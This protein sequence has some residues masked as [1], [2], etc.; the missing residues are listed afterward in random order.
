MNTEEN[1]DLGTESNNPS[2]DNSTT[3]AMTEKSLADIISKKLLGGEEQAETDATNTEQA[4]TE[5]DC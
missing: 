3:P 5:S 1:S 2:I 4:E